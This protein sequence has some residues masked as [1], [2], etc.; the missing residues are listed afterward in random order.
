[1]SYFFG[2]FYGL[3][4]KCKCSLALVTVECPPVGNLLF[5]EDFLFTPADPGFP[6][7]TTLRTHPSK[8]AVLDKYYGYT[9]S[10]HWIIAFVQEHCPEELPDK[11]PK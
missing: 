11:M 3:G 6:K 7:M 2:N 8:K 10:P 4:M 1:L 9:I 5:Q